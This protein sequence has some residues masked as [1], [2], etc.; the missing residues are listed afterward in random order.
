MLAVQQGAPNVPQADFPNAGDAAVRGASS[1]V[2]A[3]V[4]AAQVKNIEAD[5]DLK[6]SATALNIAN[7]RAAAI[8]AGISEASLP[9][10]PMLAQAT[11]QGADKQ[12]AFLQTQINNIS[13]KTRGEKLSND[14]LEKMQPLLLEAQR[15]LNAGV[16]ADLVRKE[17]YGRLWSIVPE[18]DTVDSILEFLRSPG[19]WPRKISE[20]GERHGYRGR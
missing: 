5:T 20:W 12:I 18:Q 6:G 1:A 16:S 11:A 9:W 2:A 14:Q 15:L 17:V 8:Q 10:A 4:A 19:D 3:R 7:T 13:E